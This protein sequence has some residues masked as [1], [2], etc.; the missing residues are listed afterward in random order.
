M[1]GQRRARR[2]HRRLEVLGPLV[3]IDIGPF[4]R[5]DSQLVGNVLVLGTP[6]EALLDIVEGEA[7]GEGL[8]ALEGRGIHID[9]PLG[10][11]GHGTGEPVGAVAH[12]VDATVEVA[13]DVHL[14]V[15]RGR[16]REDGLHQDAVAPGVEGLLLVGEFDLFLRRAGGCG[17]EKGR[18]RQIR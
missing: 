18:Y 14:I 17:E 13:D 15:G 2:I 5:A 4:A 10:G 11:D 8:A 3:G 6:L 16:L 7:V 12:G 1:L 9:T